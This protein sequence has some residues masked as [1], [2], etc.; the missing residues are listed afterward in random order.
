M[1]DD[2]ICGHPTQGGDGPPCQHPASEGDSCW[3][4]AHGGD[5]TPG[6]PS[7]FN[8]ERANT[9][10]EAA[11]RGKSKAGCARAAGVG[12]ATLE[13]WQDEHDEFRSAFRRARSAGED[14]LIDDGLRDPDTDSSMAKF[15]LSTSFDYVKTEKREHST[16]EGQGPLMVIETNSDA[17]G[18]N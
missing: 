7:K 11:R 15:L 13:R 5:A 12:E 8:E 18:S 3:L 14:Q 9:V 4:K 10:L 17:D 16:P 2:D 1:T 6:R